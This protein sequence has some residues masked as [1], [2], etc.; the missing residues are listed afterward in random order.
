MKIKIS[1]KDFEKALAKIQGLSD[2]KGNIPILSNVLLEAK[3][4]IFKLTTTNLE[5]GATSK[6]PAY[7]E[8]EGYGLCNVIKLFQI[9]KNL[10]SSE[11]EIFSEENLVF[12]KTPNSE[13]KLAQANRDEFP[14]IEYPENFDIEFESHLL[15]N[16]LKKVKP[17]VS[18]EDLGGFTLVGIYFNINEDFLDV[19]ATD[20][21]RLHL[22]KIPL[23]SKSGEGEIIIPKLSANELMKIL[24][25]TKIS[26]VSFKDGK[27]YL[28]TDDN[29]F[30]FSVGLEGAFPNYKKPFTLFENPTINLK[31]SRD[32]LLKALKEISAIYANTKL[33]A[34]PI[35][36]EFK[37]NEFILKARHENEE[38]KIVL[39]CQIEK[40]EDFNI[41]FNLTFLIDAISSFDRHEI[42]IKFLDEDK[43]LLV[44]SP[45]ENLKTL[46]MPMKI[47]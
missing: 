32:E 47:S 3:E 43:P 29:S 27:F 10:S 13:F 37:D 9:I 2:K 21:H 20:T 7:I 16:A 36:L 14:T 45:L 19:V 22:Y 44:E 25:D 31:I 18:K 1:K 24:K 11:I 4:N 15:L 38:G 34:K 46:V 35:F 23:I 17:A 8:K 12:I 30:F 40:K 26:K 41:T 39:P 6:L 33:E 42:E 28:N 5:V